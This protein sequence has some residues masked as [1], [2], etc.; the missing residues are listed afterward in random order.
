MQHIVNIVDF[1]QV[2]TGDY[3]FCKWKDAIQE[4][5]AHF[6]GSQADKT[7]GCC[8][9][10]L[11]ISSV[12]RATEFIKCMEGVQLQIHQVM[13]TKSQE[14]VNKNRQIIASIAKMF[15]FWQSRICL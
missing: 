15:T 10:K 2:G 11:H 4:F 7:K 8:W 14:Q 5:N 13:D 3:L 1:S 12:V 9:N 6:R